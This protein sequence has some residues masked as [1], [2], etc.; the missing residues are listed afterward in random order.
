MKKQLIWK[1]A[2]S[3]G[4][5]FEK[6]TILI[7]ITE[8]LKGEF[9]SCQLERPL[10]FKNFVFFV[11][12]PKKCFERILFVQNFSAMFKSTGQSIYKYF[13]TRSRSSSD[14]A[15]FIFTSHPNPISTIIK[16]NKRLSI[17]LIK[18]VNE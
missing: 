10:P 5:N 12:N 4:Y 3:Q 17:C 1:S 18:F 14:T 11:L 16:L 7:V 15:T 13:N 8:I 6:K 9:Q 2:I